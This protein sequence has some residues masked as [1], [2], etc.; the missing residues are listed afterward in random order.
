M[1]EVLRGSTPGGVSSPVRAFEPYPIFANRC[2]GS[3]ITDVDGNRYTDLCMAYG[4]LILGHSNPDV[5][6]AVK[7]Q[8]DRGTVFGMPSEQELRLVKTICSRVPCADSVRLTNSGTEATMHAI[9][10][11]R[12]FTGKSG[13]VKMNGGFHGSND[14]LMVNGSG[15]P[16]SSGV[17]QG[18]ISDTHVVEYNDPE[19]LESFLGSGNSVAAVILEPIMGNNGVVPPEKG[20]LEDV[21]RITSEHNVL[22][23]M[24]EVIT[25]SRVSAGGAQSLYGVRPDL[26]TMGKIIGGGFPVGAIAGKREIMDHLAPFGSVYEAGT[27]SGNPVTAVAG[28]KTLEMLTSDVYHNLSKKTVDVTGSMEDSLTDRGICGC[29]QSAPSMFQVFFG[30][31]SVKN[32]KEAKTA[33]TKMFRRMFLY[34]LEHGFYLPPSAMEVEFISTAHDDESL[35]RFA[36]TFDDFLATVR[37]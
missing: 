13:I 10:L 20:Y 24:D 28:C 5:M 19:A 15:T 23:I 3:T 1:Y 32:G 2:S 8:L 27:F 31:D 29:V 6:Q 21:R 7:G 4:P 36:R 11:A 30:K 26:C 37:T 17:T 9:R 22:M 33:D 16:F 25:G 35:T 12:G 34:M 18:A 14:A